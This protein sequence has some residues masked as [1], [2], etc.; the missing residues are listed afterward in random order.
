MNAVATCQMEADNEW[1]YLGQDAFGWR[2]RHVRLMSLFRHDRRAA[3]YS[4]RQPGKTE[5]VNERHGNQRSVLLQRT[6]NLLKGSC[7]CQVSMVS[8][9]EDIISEP[10]WLYP[11]LCGVIILEYLLTNSQM[12][13]N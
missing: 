9:R 5:R 10:I 1:L 11:L 7:L 12:I 8:K 3:Y 2:E 6:L 4:C 13:P